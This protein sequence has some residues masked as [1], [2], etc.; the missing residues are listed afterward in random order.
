MTFSAKTVSD[1]HRQRLA[2]PS[3]TTCPECQETVQ[4]RE[5]E[6]HWAS[7]HPNAIP[8]NEDSERTNEVNSWFLQ[9]FPQLNLD[10][11]TT[12][13]LAGSSKTG[14][15]SVPRPE[16]YNEKLTG[17]VANSL[18]SKRP[19]GPSDRIAE[20]GD[21]SSIL[22]FPTL[23]KPASTVERNDARESVLRTSDDRQS[24][25]RNASNSSKRKDK[26]VLLRF[27]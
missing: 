17:R 10:S 7:R 14:K 20:R 21:A 26:K 22:E 16:A 2:P 12:D 6:S 9:Q 5:M 15:S 19:A 4:T 3:S 8:R 18:T 11:S 27:G 1:Q 25:S 24:S 23:P 13:N